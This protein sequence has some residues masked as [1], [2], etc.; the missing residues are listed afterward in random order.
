MYPRFLPWFTGRIESHLGLENQCKILLS[1]IK[2]LLSFIYSS[3]PMGEPEGDSFPLLLGCR[4]PRLFSDCSRQTPTGPSGSR[5]CGCAGACPR[6]LLP[7]CSLYIFLR[8]SRLVSP[9]SD[10]FFSSSGLLVS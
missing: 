2:V 7:A 6:V 8:T 3:Q 10:V 5:A 9:S 1:F 4:R